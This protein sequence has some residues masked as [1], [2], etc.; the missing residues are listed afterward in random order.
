[1]IRADIW[2]IMKMMEC[3]DQ[4]RLDDT[5]SDYEIRRFQRFAL[6]P[7]VSSE[8]TRSRGLV[9]RRGRMVGRMGEE[10]DRRRIGAQ[11]LATTLRFRLLQEDYGFILREMWRRGVYKR[12][13]GVSTDR[14]IPSHTH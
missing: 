12:G 1:M 10:R 11:P 7:A 9:A 6:Q 5:V 8:A 14:P 3:R 2:L 13:K 4:D